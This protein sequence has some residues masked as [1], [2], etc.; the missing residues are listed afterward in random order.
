[1]TATRA[2]SATQVSQLFSPAAGSNTL[3]RHRTVQQGRSCRR[4]AHQSFSSRIVLPNPS[5][6]VLTPHC[7]DPCSTAPLEWSGR[8][9]KELCGRASGKWEKMLSNLAVN[10]AT[11]TYLGET[12][13][14]AAVQPA[15]RVPAPASPGQSARPGGP[16]PTGAAS[17]PRSSRPSS[18]H[19]LQAYCFAAAKMA[20]VT[21]FLACSSISG[22]PAFSSPVHVDPFLIP[23]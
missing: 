13:T 6:I 9:T 17:F 2:C 23:M 12:F 11:V 21:N 16:V 18:P 4:S 10:S 19:A 1:M 5:R 20:S 22:C 3:R 7:N 14:Q 8:K 15:R